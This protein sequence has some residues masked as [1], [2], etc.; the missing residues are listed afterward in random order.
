MESKTLSL[1]VVCAWRENC[2]KK[3]SMPADLSFNCPDYTKILGQKLTKEKSVKKKCVN[4][5]ETTA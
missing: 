3:F 5:D 4:H 1:C 2:S